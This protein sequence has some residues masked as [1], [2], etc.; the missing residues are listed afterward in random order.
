MI[1][2]E[3]RGLAFVEETLCVTSLEGFVKV[4][5]SCCC[6]LLDTALP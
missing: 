6:S 4:L 5:L 3:R 2:W 1:S